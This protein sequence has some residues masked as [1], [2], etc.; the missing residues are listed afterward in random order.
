[1]KAK[2]KRKSNLKKTRKPVFPKALLAKAAELVAQKK[3][4]PL[5]DDV[6]FKLFLSSPTPESNACLRYMLSA[7]TGREVTKARVTNSEVLPE[8]ANG[9]MPRM[10]INCKFNDGQKADIE[11]Q[12]TKADDDQKLRSLYYVCKL[13]AGSLGRGE[14]YRNVPNVYQIFLI[15]FDLF[16]DG[17][18]YHRA[19][20]RLDD[21]KILSDRLQVLFFSLR[22]P[23]SVDESLKKAANWCKFISGSTSPEVLEELGSNADW[24]EEYGMAMRA[25]QNVSAEERAWAWHLSMDRAEADYRNGLELAEEKGRKQ[26]LEDGRKQGLIEGLHNLMVSMSWTAAQAMDALKIPEADRNKYAAMLTEN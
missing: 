25:Y 12:L 22:V 26:G 1:M 3:L 15:D 7:M 16:G 8:Y 13:Y 9:K 4:I 5:K 10:D 19:M 17:E 6:S 2:R 20:M 24:K 21:G 11:L 23:D 18:F 14:K